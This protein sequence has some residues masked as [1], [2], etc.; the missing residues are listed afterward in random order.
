MIAYYKLLDML[1]KK[2]MTKEQLRMRVEYN[3]ILDN[4]SIGRNFPKQSNY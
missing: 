3:T 4:L 2:G 1:N